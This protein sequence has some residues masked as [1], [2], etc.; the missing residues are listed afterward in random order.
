MATVSSSKAIDVQQ[1]VAGAAK[2]ELK[3]LNAGVEAMQVYLNQAARFSNVAAETLQALQDDKATVSDAA[4]KLTEFGRENTKAF[5]EL[6]QRLSASYFD[7]IDKL[8]ASALKSRKAGGTAPAPTA[9]ARRRS[10]RKL[11]AA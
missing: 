6:S 4:R 2:L 1:L 10:G 3:L 7:E 5:A 9:K 8:A 11:T